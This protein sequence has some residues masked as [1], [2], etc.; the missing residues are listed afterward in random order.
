MTT[1]MININRMGQFCLISSLWSPILLHAWL[2][3]EKQ[4]NVI[5][6]PNS[7]FASLRRSSAL[8]L[9]CLAV[10]Y[11]KDVDFICS[12]GSSQAERC[13]PIIQ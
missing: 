3:G 13:I 2:R 7:L 9:Q 6:V 10:A 1:N 5:S 8:P 11:L 4:F 12:L